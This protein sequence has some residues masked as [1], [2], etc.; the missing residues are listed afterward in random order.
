MIR[1]F[2]NSGQNA[3]HHFPQ[4][5]PQGCLQEIRSL[6]DGRKRFLWRPSLYASP[7]IKASIWCRRQHRTKVLQI[8]GAESGMLRN[9]SQ[10]FGADFVAIV[11][12]ENE[13][14][15]TVTR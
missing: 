2:R 5:R 15:P 14:R 1:V 4:A 8:Y 12:G 3:T 9:P 13:I 7:G 6:S 10:H 11:K